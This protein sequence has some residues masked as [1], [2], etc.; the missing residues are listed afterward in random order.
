MTETFLLIEKKIPFYSHHGY[1]EFFLNLFQ[2]IPKGHIFPS[3]FLF[4]LIALWHT[5][6]VLVILFFFFLML[7]YFIT[8]IFNTLKPQFCHVLLSDVVIFVFFFL[9]LRIFSISSHSISFAQS[10]AHIPR[11]MGFLPTHF[12]I[13]F[14][15]GL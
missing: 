4:L 8:I 6:K 3:H 15:R 14:D 7:R 2:V 11:Y 1:Y 9:I 5:G 13:Y 12:H 10:L